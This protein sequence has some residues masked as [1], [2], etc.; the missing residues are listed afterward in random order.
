MR[1]IVYILMIAVL[2]LAS[3]CSM[4]QGNYEYV[5]LD[6]PVISGLEDQDVLT[7]SRLQIS[8]KVEGG[9]FSGQDYDY[10]WM[11]L[12]Q[13]MMEEPV[14]ISK[15]R[16]LD[17]TVELAPG[18]YV[19]YFTITEKETG[20][21]WRSNA[22]LTVS[23]SLSEGWMVLC[24]DGNRAR[25]DMVSKVTG[26]TV[27][28]VLKENGMPQMQGPRRIQWLSDKTD[29]SSPYY[30]LTDDG[31]TRLGKDAFEWKPEYDFA[32]EAALNEKLVPH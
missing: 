14:V 24:S 17:Y 28:D 31:A 27:K 3:A 21:Y 18:A 6:E 23:S 20:L 13:N 15:E 10:E 7:F 32:Y 19:L 22:D 12:N 8:P 30:L 4:D 5:T 9:D 16:N 1:N 11:V 2:F 26:Q 25:L 29:E